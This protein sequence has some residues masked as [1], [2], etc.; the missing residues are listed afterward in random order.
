M[1]LLKSCLVSLYNERLISPSG[2]V[3]SGLKS[4]VT[5]WETTLANKIAAKRSR[6]VTTENARRILRGYTRRIRV[7]EK[8]AP[9]VSKASASAISNA[10][11]SVDWTSQARKRKSVRERRKSGARIHS[12][13]AS[14]RS[15]LDI[16]IKKKPFSLTSV[17]RDR[18]LKALHGKRLTRGGRSALYKQYTASVKGGKAL[19]AA[20]LRSHAKTYLSSK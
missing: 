8:C 4:R 17:Q 9:R 5:R 12:R 11:S 1:P 13:K 3:K 10:V 18:F 2:K 20:A 7:V 19:T 16:A 6:G 14:G 15:Q